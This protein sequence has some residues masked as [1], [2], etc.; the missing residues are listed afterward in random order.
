MM[1][2]EADELR[3]LRAERAA[4]QAAQEAA[5]RL[6]SEYETLIAV[7]EQEKAATADQQVAAA[8]QHGETLALNLLTQLRTS[9]MSCSRHA[10]QE[11]ALSRQLSSARLSCSRHKGAAEV[12]RSHAEVFVAAE[13]EADASAD[14]L[15]HDVA[16]LRAQ[17]AEEQQQ[18]KRAWDLSGQ[19][20]SRVHDLEFQCA[21]LSVQLAQACTE[22][23]SA[24]EAIKAAGCEL[25]QKLTTFREEALY[26]AGCGHLLGGSFGE[27][28][29]KSAQLSRVVCAE[30][31]RLEQRA[32]QVSGLQETLSASRTAAHRR[33]SVV[34]EQMQRLQTLQ[35]KVAAEEGSG[36]KVHELERE[37]ERSEARIMELT[38]CVEQAQKAVKDASLFREKEQELSQQVAA[39]RNS[40]CNRDVRITQLLSHREQEKQADDLE[41]K[42][43]RTRCAQAEE[44]AEKFFVNGEAVANLATQLDST[45]LSCSNHANREDRLG[46]ELAAVLAQQKAF[47]QRVR[48]Q[49]AA[50]ATLEDEHK[51]YC[52]TL[53]RQL[54]KER[55]QAKDD[56]ELVESELRIATSERDRLRDATVSLTADLQEQAEEAAE[57]LAAARQEAEALRTQLACLQ[58][59][60]AEKMAVGNAQLQEQADA[61]SAL[62]QRVGEHEALQHNRDSGDAAELRQQL[63]GAVARIADLEA[64]ATRMQADTAEKMSIGNAQLKDQA[65]TIASLQRRLATGEEANR[66]SAMWQ[67]KC[68]QAETALA[69]LQSQLEERYSDV[70][71]LMSTMEDKE[72]QAEFEIE[73]LKCELMEKEKSI[74]EMEMQLASKDIL[75]VEQ[76]A[77][78]DNT[79]QSA[80]QSC[81]RRQ[82]QLQVRHFPDAPPTRAPPPQPPPSLQ[83]IT[84]ELSNA[85]QMLDRRSKECTKLKQQASATASLQQ[86][87]Q[88]LRAAVQ[89][90]RPHTS[91]PCSPP[92]LPPHTRTTRHAGEGCPEDRGRHAAGADRGRKDKGERQLA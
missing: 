15:R 28:E 77:E 37:L 67:T 57:G 92:P 46:A 8:Q 47:E 53:F 58:S 48:E 31:S 1:N 51:D 63:A 66:L 38:G 69:S 89:V 50:K 87:N 73:G 23:T 44:A 76:H 26:D 60:T 24:V 45:R 27:A 39:A 21:A 12:L 34:A 79:L 68:A 43:L 78:A 62:Q 10:H 30:L 70:G 22:G 29:Q 80:R 4:T 72:E 19:Q 33:D 91:P 11:Q 17:L 49:E 71:S 5:R 9:R 25:H 32:L 82:R 6:A 81:N 52:A 74:E 35:E 61:I 64:A 2:Q 42:A 3:Q 54:S 13:D 36:E 7:V 55:A 85:K 83:D 41:L 90:R 18:C 88:T 65:E 59:N 75:S 16:A 40:T 56:M 84:Q 14:G 86:E 20:E